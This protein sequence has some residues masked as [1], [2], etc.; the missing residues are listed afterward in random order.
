MYKLIAVFIGGGLG[1]MTRYGISRLITTGA[2]N[3]KPWATLLSNVL[4]TALLGIILF[5]AVVKFQWSEPFQ[6]FL[7][8]G[9]C[10]GFSTFST[11]SF[12]TFE[13]MRSGHALLAV[14]YAICSL[15]LG[16]FVLFVISKMM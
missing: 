7:I 13:L 15:L 12:E 2:L 16:L 3:I 10:G 4:A 14:I 1:S 8:I 9:F 6:A 11:F 5:Y